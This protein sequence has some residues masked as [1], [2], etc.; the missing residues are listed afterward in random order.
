MKLEKR[1]VDTTLRDGEQC[2]GIVF[3]KEDKVLLAKALDLLGLWEMEVGVVSAGGKKMDF[4][5]QIMAERKQTKVSL[6]CRMMEDDMREACSMEPD[7]IHMGVPVSYVQ[8]YTKLKKN[9]IWVQRQISSCLK[10]ASEK[11]I[12][13]TIGLEDST[14]ADMGFILTLVHQ[15]KNEG[16]STIRLADTVGMLSPERAEGMIREIKTIEKGMAIEIHEHND[17]GMA[18]ANSLLMAKEGGDLIDCTLLGLGERVGNCN[19]YDFIHTAEKIFQLSID[20]G[21]VR[22]AE[23]LLIDILNRR[24]QEEEVW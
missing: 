17:L 7:L 1:I 21:Q 24:L 22:K 23:N 19:M 3:R 5:E 18:V 16:V 12:P 8:I 14:R 11:N 15:L 2:P 9:K 10:I 20:K 13:V 6:W 4:F